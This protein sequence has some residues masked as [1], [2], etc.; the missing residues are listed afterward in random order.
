MENKV[1]NKI[2]HS[3]NSGQTTPLG[4]EPNDECYTSMDTILEELSIWAKLGKFEDKNIIC[5]C[6][7]DITIDNDEYEICSITI[8]YKPFDVDIVANDVFSYVDSVEMICFEKEHPVKKTIML[9]ENEIA[10]FLRNKVKCNFIRVFTQCARRWGIKSITASGYD[11]ATSRGIKFQN[12]DYSKYDIC[13]T[14]P[15]FSKYSE[16]MD[17]V[18]GKIDFIILAPFLNRVNPNVGLPLMLKQA[19]LGFN[20]HNNI[21][22]SNPTEENGFS[23]EKRVACDWITSFLEAQIERNK[24]YANYNSNI[25]YEAYKDEFIVCENMTMRDGTHPIR[26]SSLFP[27]DYD[28]WMFA[29]VAVLDRLN[30]DEYEWY[31]TNFKKYYNTTCPQ[32]NPFAHKTSDAMVKAV[33]SS[34]HGIVFRKIINNK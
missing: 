16:F 25:K 24:E 5:P 22:F 4:T 1:L 31:G 3:T 32:N 9:A 6:D 11:P 19:Y 26:V 29:S 10:D 21:L 12:V 8:K 20:I 30:Q 28:G 27:T 18:I 2:K 33:G 15:P 23:G 7:M 14:N 17:C 34:F 13:V